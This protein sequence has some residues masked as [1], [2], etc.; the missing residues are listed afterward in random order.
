M[1]RNPLVTVV[2]VVVLAVALIFIF[3]QSAGSGGPQA[4]N[5]NWY[6]MG[7]GE[8]YGGFKMG[9]ADLP[10]I[11]LPS[12]NEGV[13][14]KVFSRTS[15]DI[16]ADR[17]IGYLEKY[18]EK[19]KVAMKAAKSQDTLDIGTV[20]HVSMNERLVMRPGDEE[21][22]V[23]GSDDGRAVWGPTREMGINACQHFL[24]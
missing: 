9:E 10:P 7:T 8:L 22:V 13:M 15:C 17:F 1:G 16:K 12:G 18:T 20:Q 2:A 19:G 11:T 6:D 21:W 14:A 5:A 23:A 24:P 3:R 4:G